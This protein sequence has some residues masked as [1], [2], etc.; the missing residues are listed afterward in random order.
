M[1]N[2]PVGLCPS[3]EEAKK[4]PLF[5]FKEI[6]GRGVVTSCYDLDSFSICLNL[7]GSPTILKT[8]L[9]GVDG[10]ELKN[11]ELLE[12]ALAYIGRDRVKE[13]CLDKE[14]TVKL[15]GGDK[16][17]R[18]LITVTLDDGRDLATLLIE[19]KLCQRYDGGSKSGLKWQDFI[20]ENHPNL[21][22]YSK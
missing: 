8:R 15:H 9:L 3:I 17:N 2:I 4:A 5:T 13:L 6:E 10:P 7:F 14:V 22:P 1:Y 18:E 16:Y 21:E 12:K 11:K 20:R 19:E